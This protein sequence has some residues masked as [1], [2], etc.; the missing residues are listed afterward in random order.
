MDCADVRV[1]KAAL[2]DINVDEAI[3][4]TAADA[5]ALTAETAARQGYW[6]TLR[7]CA[8]LGIIEGRGVPYSHS[9]PIENVREGS[10]CR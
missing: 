4:L 2:G 8:R 7:L 5:S 1:L 10:P 6:T 9:A 3:L